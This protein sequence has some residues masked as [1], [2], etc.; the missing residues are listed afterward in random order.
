MTTQARAGCRWAIRTAWARITRKLTAGIAH[1]LVDH[2]NA[3]VEATLKPARLMI[4]GDILGYTPLEI[5][6]VPVG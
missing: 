3:R 2:S 5:E 4:D 6:C 1:V